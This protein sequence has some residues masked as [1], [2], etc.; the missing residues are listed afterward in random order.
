MWA[1]KGRLGSKWKVYRQRIGP[2]WQHTSGSANA[3]LTEYN[4]C[5]EAAGGLA[6]SADC[7]PG[8]MCYPLRD[9]KSEGRGSHFKSAA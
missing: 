7:Q 2:G 4:A 3:V 8:G 6:L 1:G 9:I 5:C